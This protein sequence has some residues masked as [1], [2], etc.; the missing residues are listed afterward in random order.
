MSGRKLNGFISV[1]LLSLCAGIILRNWTHARYSE[2]A[3]GFFI[4]LSIVFIIAGAVQQ[5]RGAS[6]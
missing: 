1:G 5:R 3:A 4:G 6:R 2:F